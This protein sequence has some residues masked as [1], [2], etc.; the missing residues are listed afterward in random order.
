[1]ETNESML[2]MKGK[3]VADEISI[4]IAET[5]R[6][7]TEKRI[8]PKLAIVRVGSRP[9]DLAYERGIVKKC[10]TLG[11]ETEL[12]PLDAS[13]TTERCMEVLQDL[14]YDPSIHGIMP[15]RPMPEHIDMN[16]LKTQI[17]PHKDVDCFGPKSAAH[18]YDKSLHGFL[19]CTAEAVMEM[20]RYYGIALKGARAAILGRS[21]VV[22][23]P[24][25]LLM[26]DAHCTVTI[27]HS[28]TQD[29]ERVAAEADILIAAMG[30]ARMVGGEWVKRGAVVVDVGINGD[31][32]GG[33]CGDVDFEAVSQKC[34]AITPVPGGI[35]TVT[36]TLLVRNVVNACK[37]FTD[38]GAE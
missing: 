8:V 2:L 4:G 23:R 10:T 36:T 25:A 22:G 24:L 1:M 3:P 6:S 12:H 13:A 38:G 14:G 21:P 29:I 37:Y 17:S 35:G 34:T 26:V 33:I 19:P 11:V 27:C 28:K 16:R 30:R 9:D 31:G 7:L 5:V 18:V 20:L 32:H 15:F